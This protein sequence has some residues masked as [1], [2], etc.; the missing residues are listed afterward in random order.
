MILC[1]ATA[2]MPNM[3]YEFLYF[4]AQVNLRP[5]SLPNRDLITAKNL[6][7]HLSLQAKDLFE[8]AGGRASA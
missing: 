8:E 6:A 4:I 3:E 1:I 5:R 2:G 7:K